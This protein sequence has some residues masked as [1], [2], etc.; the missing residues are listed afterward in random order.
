MNL[1]NGDIIRLIRFMQTYPC[2]WWEWMN[3][4]RFHSHYLQLRCPWARHLTPNRS[5]PQ[6]PQQQRLPTALGVCS[7]CVYVQYSLLCVCVCVCVHLDGWNAGHKFRVCDTIL[8]YTSLHFH[9][10]FSNS[11]YSNAE[12]A[13]LAP[14]IVQ[15]ESITNY[16]H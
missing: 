10:H 7:R 1:N 16:S 3:S 6:A 15:L 13:A 9:F 14:P 2:R 12:D 8:G 5:P 11:N 4:A